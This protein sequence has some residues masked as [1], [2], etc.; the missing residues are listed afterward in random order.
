MNKREAFFD[1]MTDNFL[2]MSDDPDNKPIGKLY[3]SFAPALDY[4]SKNRFM[5]LRHNW[6]YQ[7]FSCPDCNELLG[8]VDEKTHTCPNWENYVSE[9]KLNYLKNCKEYE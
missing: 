4:L 2:S 8:Y 3:R 9:K 1:I 7:S 5:L 6:R